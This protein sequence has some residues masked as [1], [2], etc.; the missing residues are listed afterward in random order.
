MILWYYYV[1]FCDLTTVIISLVAG[2]GDEGR[3][4]GVYFIFQS[5]DTVSSL[6]MGR[7]RI[8]LRIN[9][10]LLQ[11]QMFQTGSRFLGAST[12]NSSFCARVPFFCPRRTWLCY[13]WLVENRRIALPYS[14]I[15]LGTW[16]WTSSL[17]FCALSLWDKSIFI[18]Y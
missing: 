3:S 14:F 15:T 4:W 13:S 17:I 1:L 12:S 6:N 5:R 8:L 18:C 7:T 10:L 9:S 11:T 2:K 16:S